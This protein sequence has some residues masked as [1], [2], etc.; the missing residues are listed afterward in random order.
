[1]TYAHGHTHGGTLPR[2]SKPGECTDGKAERHGDPRT[3]RRASRCALE[4]TKTCTHMHTTHRYRD[5]LRPGSETCELTHRPLPPHTRAAGAR[6]DR[7]QLVVS[8]GT[9]WPPEDWDRGRVYI[10]GS[11]GSVNGKELR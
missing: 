4:H 8:Q 10:S 1:M 7:H 9:R 5:H 6:R 11:F 3:R 2:M